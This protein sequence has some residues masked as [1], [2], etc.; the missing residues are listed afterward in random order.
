MTNRLFYVGGRSG[1]ISYDLH[2]TESTWTSS[3]ETIV[4]V[5]SMM[6]VSILASVLTDTPGVFTT[7]PR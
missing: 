5:S 1:G 4:Q 6:A 7:A 2:A 3:V